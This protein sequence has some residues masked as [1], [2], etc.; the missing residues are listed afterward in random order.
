ML[1]A[2]KRFGGHCYKPRTARPR[3]LRRCSV[4]PRQ[5]AP[6]KSRPLRLELFSIIFLGEPDFTLLTTFCLSPRLG[7]QYPPQLVFRDMWHQCHLTNVLGEHDKARHHRGTGQL[8]VLGELV[9]LKSQRRRG[10]CQVPSLENREVALVHCG[11]V[12]LSRL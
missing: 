1:E 12:G 11:P 6:T 7:R 3:R 10:C 5:A 2:R 4:Q 8:M 9:T